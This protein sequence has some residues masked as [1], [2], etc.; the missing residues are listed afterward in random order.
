MWGPT[1]TISS[2]A[3]TA[4]AVGAPWDRSV[5]RLWPLT[6]NPPPRSM[7]A[8]TMLSSRVLTA[9]RALAAPGSPSW[10]STRWPSRSEERRVGKEWRCA[11]EADDYG[12]K[13]EKAKGGR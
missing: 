4:G 2:G 13:W 11:W 10:E 12:E 8:L 7:R 5:L 3:R 9:G 1:A 6:S